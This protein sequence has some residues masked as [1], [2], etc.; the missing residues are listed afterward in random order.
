MGVYGP[1]NVHTASEVMVQYALEILIRVFRP[2]VRLFGPR[3]LV[4]KVHFG[5]HMGGPRWRRGIILGG[6]TLDT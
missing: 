3:F 2:V 1:S 5:T 6:A 4:P